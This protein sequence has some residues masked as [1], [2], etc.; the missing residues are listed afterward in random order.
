M[1]IVEKVIV[2]I[3][4]M[5]TEVLLDA[6]L[7]LR[8]MGFISNTNTL[9]FQENDTTMHNIW[10]QDSS[11]VRYDNNLGLGIDPLDRLHV[12]EATGNVVATFESGD[13]EGGIQFKD[14]DTTADFKV[15]IRAIGDDMDLRA[16][17]SSALYIDSNQLLDVVGGSLNVTKGTEVK[18]RLDNTDT[19]ITNP[20]T[21]G[22]LE[23]YGSDSSGLGEGIKGKVS[24]I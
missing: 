21:L 2:Q 13:A 6:D 24:T 23:F 20:Q 8:E 5:T 4:E 7:Q 14:S 17:G 19:N 12:Y 3:H 1:A 11:V 15:T 22:S 10:M 18:L 16:G 9:R